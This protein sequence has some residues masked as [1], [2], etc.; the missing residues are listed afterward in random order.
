MY[1]TSI[2]LLSILGSTTSRILIGEFAKTNLSFQSDAGRDDIFFATLLYGTPQTKTDNQIV[3]EYPFRQIWCVWEP[4]Y[5]YSWGFFS[6]SHFFLV[7]NLETSS[8]FPLR[9]IPPLGKFY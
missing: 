5:P 4:T 9:K 8:S 3:V 7:I 1:E 2:R 6:V